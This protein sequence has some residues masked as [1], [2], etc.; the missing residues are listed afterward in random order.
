MKR[1][2][3]DDST[4][5]SPAMAPTDSDRAV[6]NSRAALIAVL[7]GAGI[8]HFVIP[9]LYEKIVP[10]MFANPRRVVYV[11]GLAELLCGSML[12]VPKTRRLGTWSTLILFVAVY[13]ANIRMAMDAGR[14]HDVLSWGAWLRLPLQFPLFAW[15]YRH[16]RD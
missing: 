10:R 14:P 12:A 9:R 1:H 2:W 8:L 4:V 5:T 11:S 13:P 16:T 7:V 15:A 6:A 3:T